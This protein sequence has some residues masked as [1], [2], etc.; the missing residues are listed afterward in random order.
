MLLATVTQSCVQHTSSSPEG[1]ATGAA[2]W[3]LGSP[4]SLAVKVGAGHGR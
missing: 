1:P 2:Q 3:K 4:A